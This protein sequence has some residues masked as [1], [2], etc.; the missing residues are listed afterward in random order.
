MAM[1]FLCSWVAAYRSSL[2]LKACWEF[3]CVFDVSP[4]CISMVGLSLGDLLAVM[5]YGLTLVAVGCF[6]CKNSLALLWSSASDSLG[7][8]AQAT[9]SIK[10]LL[11]APHCFE[12]PIERFWAD[13][14]SLGCESVLGFCFEVSF[15]LRLLGR[16][17]VVIEAQVRRTAVLHWLFYVAQSSPVLSL[18]ILW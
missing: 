12:C 14:F 3:C 6:C 15:L 4:K 16:E 18:D 11:C 1:V 2:F 17:G 10:L 13:C 9:E 8:I 7:Y 5:F